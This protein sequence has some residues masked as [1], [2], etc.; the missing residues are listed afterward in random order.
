MNSSKNTE[1]PEAGG[2]EID[3]K[4]IILLHHFAET[5]TFSN[6]P[7]LGVATVKPSKFLFYEETHAAS[8]ASMTGPVKQCITMW[9]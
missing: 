5:T 4:F 9:S 3:A 6:E 7:K 2:L 1:I 8:S